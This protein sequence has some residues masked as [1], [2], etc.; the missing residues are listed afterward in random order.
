MERILQVNFIDDLSR[1][2]GS[3]ITEKRAIYKH[4]LGNCFQESILKLQK[5][6]NEN[7]LKMNILNDAQIQYQKSLNDLENEGELLRENII[8]NVQDKLIQ[9]KKKLGN[10]PKEQLKNYQ[11]K[12]ND[13]E[14][15]FNKS[16][17]NPFLNKTSE[18]VHQIKLIKEKEYQELKVNVQRQINSYDKELEKHYKLIKQLNYRNYTIPL[19]NISLKDI[20]KLIEEYT[21]DLE[22]KKILKK[23]Y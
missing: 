19:D 11:N 21:L 10:N 13:L 6:I 4:L 17:N 18:E 22:Q 12:L 3:I 20:N 8:P 14:L 2:A 23:K 15:E 16:N 7:L 9:L 1:K 5:N